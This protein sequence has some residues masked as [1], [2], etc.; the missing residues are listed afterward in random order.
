MKTMTT[1]F[2][3]LL[4]LPVLA[5]TIS[6]SEEENEEPMVMDSSTIVD[7]AQDEEA[8]TS[9]VA[10][11]TTADISEATDLVGTLNSDDPF[12]VFAPTN[13]AFI[14]LLAQLDG[15]DSLEDFDTDEER[16]ILAKIL[17]YHVV[18]GTAAASTDLTDG[19]TVSTVQGEDVTISLDGG[20]FLDDATDTNAEV[21]IP[22]VMAS[23]GI[24]HVIDKV[25]L[26][27]EIIDALNSGEMEN[28][29]GTLVDIVVD[30]EALSIRKLR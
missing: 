9:L 15:F 7:I 14:S 25:L 18:A 2:K 30:T 8:L 21:I 11:L 12:T 28:E 10:A 4:L 22:D 16:A 29:S 19:M 24:V 5:F 1:Y 27:Q 17:T 26:P 23:N 6:C 13:D 3:P 20:V